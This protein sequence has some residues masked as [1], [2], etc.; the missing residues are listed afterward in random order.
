MGERSNR[1]LRLAW[2]ACF[3]LA[4]CGSSGS[5]PLAG[6]DASVDGAPDTPLDAATTATLHVLAFNDFHGALDAVGSRGGA[7]YLAAAIASRRTPGTVVVSA[8]DLT[9]ASPLDSALFHDEPTI[10]VMNAMGL[11][12]AGVGNHEFDEGNAELQRLQ[13]G[14]CHPVDGCTKGQTFAGAKFHYLAANVVAGASSAIFP[15]YEIRQLDGVKVA[16]IGLTLKETPAVTLASAIPELTFSGE[17]ATVNALLPELHAAGAQVV[18]VLLH[19]GGGQSGG[20]DECKSLRGPIVD[21]A[22]ALDGKVAM[23]ASGHTHQTYNCKVGQ[24]VVT[25]AGSSGA[26]LT[27]ATLRV[28]R[29]TGA[30]VSTEVHNVAIGAMS[31]PDPAV[32]D[33][34]AHY[35]ALVAP[36]RDRPVGTITESFG[37]IFSVAGETPLGDVI[38]DAMLEATSATQGAEVALMN[39]GGI[40]AGLDYAAAPGEPTDGI[41]TYGEAFAVQPFGNLVSTVDLRGA[42]LVAALDFWSSGAVLQVAGLTYTWHSSA[43]PGSRVTASDVLVKGVPLDPARTYRVTVNSIV[44]SPVTTPSMVN[45]K[46]AVGAGVDLDILLAYLKAHSP[47]PVP[48]VDRIATAP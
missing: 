23:I 48:S 42:D 29:A 46:N 27:D 9:G 12:L 8:G 30:I 45:A 16:F 43:A 35:D 38:A 21:I 28:D 18:V 31:A 41:V 25:S 1:G 36:L 32:A 19:Q 33:I 39:A 3:V 2:L 34:V 47:I 26:A 15:A 13:H 10:E 44:G 24:V 11:D 40:R 7:A 20:L 14:G 37:G 17:V 6:N 5:A 22:T 4:G